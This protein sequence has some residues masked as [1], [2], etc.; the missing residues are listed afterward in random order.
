MKIDKIKRQNTFIL[1]GKQFQN[2]LIFWI[3][4]VFQIEKNS[5]NL[6][7][8]QFKKFQKCLISQ[9]PK[10]AIIS[11]F[12]KKQEFSKFNNLRN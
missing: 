6:L 3:S 2:L 8:F 1:R 7:I 4:M 11:Q 5:G 9:F 10:I 12:K